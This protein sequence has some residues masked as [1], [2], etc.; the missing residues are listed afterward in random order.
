MR[1]NSFGQSVHRSA[2]RVERF[3]TVRFP[4]AAAERRSRCRSP[5]LRALSLRAGG[6]GDARRALPRG[7]R[8]PGAGA[9]QAPARHRRRQGGDRRLRRARFDAGADRVRAR[10]GRDGAAAREHPRLHH[11]G[12]RHQRAHARPGAAAD[13]RG[14]LHAPTRSTSGR[15]A[16]RCSRTSAIR[17]PRASR[18]T[19][20]PSRTCRRASAP[21][22][23][24]GSP[25]CTA[26]RWWAPA[27]CP[28]WRWA[29]RTYGVGD[30]M[31]H[32]HVN[33]SVPKTLIQYL[34]RYVARTK[35]LGRRCEPRSARR[36]G[37]RPSAPSWCPARARAS[38]DRAPKRS[39]GP[40]ELQDF[41]LYYILRFGYLPSK[42]AFMAWCAWRDRAL[43]DWP[44]IP[45]D[46]RN[47]VRDRRDQALAGGVRAA[48]LPVDPVQAQRAF[49]TRPKVGSGGSLSPRSDWRAPS[50]SEAAVWLAGCRAHS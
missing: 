22:T 23:C 43:G 42:V 45:E 33:A 9:G 44:D 41:H 32:Y 26:R 38:R 34:I 50:D 2:R 8:D 25:T 21:A 3:R 10:H 11:A 28:S 40:Y 29:G 37:H 7:L 36:A 6:P 24:S 19:T 14:R 49:P 4:A 39:I 15:A 18:S 1:T 27:T 20:S 48:L 30:H 16:C 12:L 47:A 46:R 5:R 35:Q 17:S 31:A 13:A